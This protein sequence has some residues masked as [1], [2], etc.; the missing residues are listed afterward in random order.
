[1]ANRKLKLSAGEIYYVALGKTNKGAHINTVIKK[2]WI[3]KIPVDR[4]EPQ[5]KDP[6]IS[7]HG[8][9]INEEKLDPKARDKKKVWFDKHE[10][11]FY[12][13]TIMSAHGKLHVKVTQNMN[14]IFPKKVRLESKIS[15]RFFVDFLVGN[16]ECI[17]PIYFQSITIQL[18][19]KLTR[20]EL[21]NQIASII[22]PLILEPQSITLWD[23][24]KVY[25]LICLRL[26]IRFKQI[27][28]NIFI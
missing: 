4:Q 17:N 20:H 23:I 15:F 28:F 10:R 21:E 18:L 22:R 12:R 11:G 2:S 7:F 13:F 19:E 1:M 25:R 24:R 8:I 26:S 6:V 14:E 27:I 9:D 3:I 5:V 16:F